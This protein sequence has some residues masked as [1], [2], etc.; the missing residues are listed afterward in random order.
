MYKMKILILP[1]LLISSTIVSAQYNELVLK[2]NGWTKSRYREGSVITIETKLGMNYTGPVYLIQKD[3][4]YFSGSAIAISDIAAV[5]KKPYRKKPFIP[6]SKE[7]FLYA[8]GGIPLFVAGLVI[9]GQSL[10]SAIAAGFAIVYLPVLIY[11]AQRL[12][13]S[14]SKVYNIG[15]RYQLHVLDFFTPENVPFNKQ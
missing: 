5:R 4:V 15:N 8:N 3:S 1:I 2:K 11:N 13:F 6:Y 12:L 7:M 10:S 9:S 14:G